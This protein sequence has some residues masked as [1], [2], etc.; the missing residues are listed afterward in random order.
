MVQLEAG[1]IFG[2]EVAAQMCSCLLLLII[3]GVRL[4]PRLTFAFKSAYRQVPLCSDMLT[5]DRFYFG[6]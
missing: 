5:C 3:L 6:V 1:Q 2:E 4:L